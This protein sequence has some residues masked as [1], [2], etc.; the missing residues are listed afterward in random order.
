VAFKVPTGCL[1]PRWEQFIGQPK[2]IVKD[3][4]P[5]LIS[6]TYAEDGGHFFALEHPDILAKDFVKFSK[7]AEGNGDLFSG[8]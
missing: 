7:I 5:N 4:S 1:V 6:Y 8:K 2:S 3:T